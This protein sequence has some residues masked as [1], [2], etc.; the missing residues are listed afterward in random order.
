ML[1]SLVLFF[2]FSLLFV[3]IGLY[4]HTGRQYKY[5]G[6]T[7]KYCSILNVHEEMLGRGGEG[8]SYLL[9][10]C[11]HERS[12]KSR[13]IDTLQYMRRQDIALTAS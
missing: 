4:I 3:R 6:A 7:L 13:A 10:S 11:F 12:E 2:L 8:S 5:A 1:S 9:P